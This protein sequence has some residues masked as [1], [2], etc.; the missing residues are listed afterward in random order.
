MLVDSEFLVMVSV[1]CRMM[2]VNARMGSRVMVNTNVNVRFISSGP[3][4]SACMSST[5]SAVMDK[6]EYALQNWFCC[7]TVPTFHLMLM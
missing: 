6:F 4:R 1:I 2:A 3:F 5:A 7:L